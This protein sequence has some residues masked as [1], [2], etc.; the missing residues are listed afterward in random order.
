M[1]DKRV[2]RKNI[3]GAGPL[4]VYPWDKLTLTVAEDGAARLW[5]KGSDGKALLLDKTK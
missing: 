2:T 5:T 3:K 1:V 4:P